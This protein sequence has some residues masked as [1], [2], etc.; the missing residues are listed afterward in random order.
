LLL[1]AFA[2][3]ATFFTGFDASLARVD[4]FLACFLAFFIFA[5]FEMF[6]TC[7]DTI[8]TAFFTIL[9]FLHTGFIA[10]FAAF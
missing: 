2:F 4:A 1:V 8:L 5:V 10:S 3:S 6:L 7:V 9:T